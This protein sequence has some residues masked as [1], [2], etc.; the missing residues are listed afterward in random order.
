MIRSGTLYIGSIQR[1]WNAVDWLR[2]KAKSLGRLFTLVPQSHG[3]VLTETRSTTQAAF[4][5]PNSV[6]YIFTDPPFGDNLMY[7]E[8]NFLWEGWLKVFT[9]Q[10]PEAVIA[11]SQKK[12]FDAYTSL[13]ESCFQTYYRALKPGRWMTVV[14]HNSRNAVW[15]AIQEGL[16]RAGFV[17]ADVRTI[18]KRQRSFN[19]VQAARAVKQDLVISAYKPNG[20]LEERFK[21]QSG[22]EE[23]AWDFVLRPLGEAPSLCVAGRKKRRPVAE[24]L[25][26]L[27]F[28]R[29]VAFHIE[30]GVTVPLS[31]AEFY[32]G[33]EQRFTP[34]DGMYFLSEQIP[35]YDKKR[36]SVKEVIQLEL[37]VNDEVS[38]IQWL[39][40]QLTQKPQTFQELHPQFMTEIAGWEKHEK[41]LELL[42]LLDE[43]FLMFDGNGE[44]PSQV[45]R[46]LSSNF[47]EL[48]NLPK[49]HPNL[50]SKATDRWYIPDPRK[51]GDL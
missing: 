9:N 42:T 27:L 36:L 10:T 20:E 21:L 32:S 24:R 4:L 12:G 50:R 22:T 40:H 15:N 34:R 1:E 25:N 33:L 18:D 39:R 7:S 17:V 6:D 47:K 19:Q 29:M 35:L 43:N 45:H 11:K 30:R 48:R 38:A 37:Y 28:D 16:Q 14:F 3:E 46:Y 49:H 44:V 13:M 31:A 41:R 5:P 23:G 2:G 8:L 26:Y 51:A